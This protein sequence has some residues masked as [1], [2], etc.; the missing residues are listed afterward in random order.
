MAEFQPLIRNP[1]LLTIAGNFWPRKIDTRRFPP[2]WKRYQIDSRTAVSVIEHQP[3]TV[4]RGQLVLLHG[5]EGSANAGY[6]QSFAQEALTRGFGVHRAN[7]RTCGGTEEMS[8]TSYHSGLT[9]DTE[10]ILRK[11]EARERGPIYLVGFSLGGNVALKLTGELGHTSLLAGT[12]AISTPIDLA[13]CVCCLDKRSNSLYAR[14]FLDRLRGRV[15]RKSRLSPDLYSTAGL[16]SVKTIWEFDDRFTAPLFGFGTAAKYYET[17]S[18]N[19]YLKKICIPT[20][21]ICAKD[22]PL[23]PFGIYDHPAFRSNAALT[24]LTPEHG[25]HLGFISRHKPRFWLDGTVLDWIEGLLHGRRLEEQTRY[26]LR[27]DE[28]FDAPTT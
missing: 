4:R 3:E 25:G 21:V 16:D 13:A 10:H 17:Q 7:F 22:D 8:E 19:T 6:I 24:L 15:R 20:L 5:L 11:I 2:T 9:S 26:A 28:R 14:R 18:A 27:L 23:V 1:H 12:C